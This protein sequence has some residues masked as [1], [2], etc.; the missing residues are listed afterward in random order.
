MLWSQTGHILQH[1][2]SM[3]FACWI[4]KATKTYSE[5]VILTVFPRQQWLR[6]RASMLRYTHIA[7]LVCIPEGVYLLRDGQTVCKGNC[8]YCAMGRQSVKVIQVNFRLRCRL[9]HASY[10]YVRGTGGL[11]R[12]RSTKISAALTGLFL[13]SGQKFA[14]LEMKAT[15][16]A[17]LR[18][19]K[20]SLDDPNETLR[21]ILELVMKSPSGTRLKLE[22]RAWSAPGP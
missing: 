6:E 22:P 16:S 2:T 12:A 1:N 8:I 9:P 5:Y 13:L 14:M 4:L 11:S 21:F 18:H 7:C 15:I 3:R 19:Y 17:M 20:L 10:S